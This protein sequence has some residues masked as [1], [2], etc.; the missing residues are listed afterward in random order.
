MNDYENLKNDKVNSLESR[1]RFVNSKIEGVQKDIAAEKKSIDKNKQQIRRLIKEF[2]ERSE[3]LNVGGYLSHFIGNYVTPL[4]H[5]VYA[6]LQSSYANKCAINTRTRH[7]WNW[8]LRTK[9]SLYVK[10]LEFYTWLQQFDTVVSLELKIRQI[11]RQIESALK[12]VTDYMKPVFKR[13]KKSAKEWYKAIL[14][15]DEKKVV[16]GTFSSSI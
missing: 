11:M 8:I 13:I 3:G 4:L 2:N 7:I 1:I 10:Y 9:D 5:K 15:G 12:P 16:K 6:F 14:S